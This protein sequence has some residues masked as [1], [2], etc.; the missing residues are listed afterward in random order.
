MID[1]SDSIATIRAQLEEGSPRNLTYAALECRL[2][3][4]RICYERLRAMHDYI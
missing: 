3:L 1:L 4:E 2:A